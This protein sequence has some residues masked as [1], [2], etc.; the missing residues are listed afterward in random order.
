[1]SAHRTGYQPGINW[2]LLVVFA[3]SLGIWITAGAMVWWLI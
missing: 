3:L 1:M 2:P